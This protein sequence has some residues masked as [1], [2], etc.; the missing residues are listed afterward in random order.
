MSM[1]VRIACFVAVVMVIFQFGEGLRAEVLTFTI[2]SG[3]SSLSLQTTVS[4]FG[5]SLP[6]GSQGPGSLTAPISGTIIADVTPTSF[7]ILSGSE[8]VIGNSGN[9]RPGTDYSDYV[10]FPTP[11]GPIYLNTAV[12]ANYGISAD[13]S[14]LG[15]SST[16][17]IAVRDL[18]IALLDS[19][20]K[21]L[22][23]GSFDA[24]GTGTDFTSGTVYYGAGGTPP[25]TD[26]ANTVYP[27]PTLV[28]ASQG[29]LSS[30]G[31][32]A[33]LTLPF[34]N[35]TTFTVNF[36][37]ITTA[38]SGNIV[39]TAAVPE[40]TSAALVFVASVAAVPVLLYKSRQR[41]CLR[42]ASP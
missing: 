25:L 19:S 3:A 9:W 18:V 41:R 11:T 24:S 27:G 23:S 28:T 33:T 39:A 22:T 26:L 14:D 10:P 35:S 30:A 36:L 7:Q 16:T 32:L 15:F 8:L 1:R 6:T 37:G 5:K 21:S 42:R 4:L 12:P 38:F 2:D 13:L 34:S 31:S 29:E 20:A 17:P 40:P